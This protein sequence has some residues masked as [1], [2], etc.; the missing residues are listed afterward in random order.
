MNTFPQIARIARY[1]VLIWLRRPRH[2]IVSVVM[3]VIFLIIVN[4]LFVI[5][6]GAHMRMGVCVESNT[7]ANSVANELREVGL[8]PYRYPEPGTAE[9]DLRAGRLVG[10]VHVHGSAP[11]YADLHFAGR[12]PL[13][14][15][16]LAHV[17]LRAAVRVS[18][19]DAESLQISMRNDRYEPEYMRAFMAASM[20]P[21]CL[22]TITAVNYGLRWVDDWQ[23]GRLF[24]TL[25]TPVSRLA[26]VSGRT[27]AGLVVS[28]VILALSL[29]LC[30]LLVTWPWPED[31]LP[32]AGVIGVQ[33]FC[34]CG[35]FFA[36]ATW[37][38]RNQLYQDTATF[39]LFLLMFLSGA[40]VPVETMPHWERT[41]AHMTPAFYAVRT[42]RA[43]VLEDT[44][45]LMRDLCV[46]AAWGLVF[47]VAGYALLQRARIAR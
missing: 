18:E 44:P 32:W 9:A 10:Y 6:L 4:H 38:K 12:N 25:V 13:L 24:T 33:A 29:L 8:T 34:V 19:E 15:R 17:L 43:A 35:F 2:A 21:F 39:L 47:F 40:V 28:C 46:L 26:I 11:R 5:W 14:D 22:F 1:Q 45:L 20:L 7:L 23:Q 37:C 36:L 3:A 42:M 31:V 16:E 30:R 27:T 41:V